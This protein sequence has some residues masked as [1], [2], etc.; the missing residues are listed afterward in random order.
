VSVF[1]LYARPS[2]SPAPY[3]PTSKC[4][5]VSFPSPI[6]PPDPGL[7]RYTSRLIPSTKNRCLAAVSNAG[8][9]VSVSPYCPV[10]NIVRTSSA[11]PYRLSPPGRTMWIRCMESVET[12]SVAVAGS[13]PAPV[14]SCV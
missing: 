8:S 14:G 13:N 11:V 12:N 6:T 3:C 10:P 9:S 7:R 1:G 2:V 5:T 4:V